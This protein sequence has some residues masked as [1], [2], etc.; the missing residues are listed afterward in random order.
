MIQRVVAACP[1]FADGLPA[2]VGIEVF[3]P[4]VDGDVIDPDLAALVVALRNAEH[5]ESVETCTV[6]LV[7]WVEQTDCRLIVDGY[8]ESPA[9]VVAV[10]RRT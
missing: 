4:S 10:G 7:A 5:P 8:R 3:P 2:G 1:T 9:A 6:L